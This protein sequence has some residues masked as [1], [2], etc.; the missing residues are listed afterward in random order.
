MSELALKN[1]SLKNLK[2]KITNSSSANS[3]KKSLQLTGYYEHSYNTFSYNG[4]RYLSIQD[5]L[6]HPDLP[7]GPRAFHRKGWF[8]LQED[9]FGKQEEDS[10]DC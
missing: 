5:H 3:V 8:Q 2:F 1:C 4:F 7:Q 6:P 10:R 9:H